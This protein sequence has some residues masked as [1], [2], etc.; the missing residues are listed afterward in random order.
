M[1]FKKLTKMTV[2]NWCKTPIFA[3]GFQPIAARK[4]ARF[5]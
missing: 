2:E 5:L 3:I 1:I 4:M